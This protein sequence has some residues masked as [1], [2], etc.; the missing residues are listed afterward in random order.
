MPPLTPARCSV[1]I[2][3]TGTRPKSRNEVAHCAHERDNRGL[4]FVR[5]CL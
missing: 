4:T 1:Q 3:R 2:G 5:L